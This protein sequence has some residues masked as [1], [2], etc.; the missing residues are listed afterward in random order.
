[1]IAYTLLSQVLRA[2]NG[3]RLSSIWSKKIKMYVHYL[4]RQ[5]V[6]CLSPSKYTKYRVVSLNSTHTHTHLHARAKLQLVEVS[7]Y[8]NLSLMTKLV[9]LKLQS[10]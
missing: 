4:D 10:G 7:P 2:R 9:R 1:M 5:V 6:K 8:I 3:V